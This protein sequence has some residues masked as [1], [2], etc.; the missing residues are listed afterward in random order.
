[1]ELFG[2]AAAAHLVQ[3]CAHSPAPRHSTPPHVLN[4]FLYSNGSR[5]TNPVPPARWQRGNR[6][7]LS[8]VFVVRKNYLSGKLML[9]DT[10]FHASIFL[11][12]QSPLTDDGRT[13]RQSVAGVHGGT[14]DTWKE[15][16]VLTLCWQSNPSVQPI[17]FN[18]ISAR[19]VCRRYHP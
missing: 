2:G 8:K 1:M 10:L 11:E 5:K 3:I 4:P 17:S 18:R 15:K 13:G 9:I 7:K 6:N 16:W 12:T 19:I 14:L